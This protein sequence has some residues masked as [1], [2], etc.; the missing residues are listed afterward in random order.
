MQSASTAEFEQFG[1][2]AEGFRY[3]CPTV[4]LMQVVIQIQSPLFYLRYVLL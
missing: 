1:F 2:Y 4:P 3:E